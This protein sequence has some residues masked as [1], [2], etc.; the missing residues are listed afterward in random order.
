MFF[1]FFWVNNT[2]TLIV[3][4]KPNKLGKLVELLCVVVVSF[5][6]VLV[7]IR[8]V[9]VIVLIGVVVICVVWG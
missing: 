4:I 2:R 3:I 5:V 1:L 6:V 9:G 8:V 7:V